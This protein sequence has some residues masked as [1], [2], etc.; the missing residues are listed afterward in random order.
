MNVH[1]HLDPTFLHDDDGLTGR[2]WN[3]FHY[4]GVR[5]P[6]P[7]PDVLSVR[8]LRRS[9]LNGHGQNTGDRGSRTHLVRYVGQVSLRAT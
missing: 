2:E 1:S 5:L 9:I 6:D 7:G 3:I 8:I 4:H